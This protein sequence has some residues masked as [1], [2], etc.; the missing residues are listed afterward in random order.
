MNL[1]SRPA[2]P[3]LLLAVLGAISLAQVAVFRGETVNAFWLLAAAVCVHLLA[4]RF[5]AAWI[6]A[7]VLVID[8]TRATPA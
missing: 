4:Y 5:Y 8:P 2:W 1:P 7:R 6:A 3:W